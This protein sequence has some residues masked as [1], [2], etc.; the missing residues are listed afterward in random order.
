MIDC[1]PDAL[2]RHPN[3]EVYIMDNCIGCGNCA[4]NCPYGVIQ[5]AAVE[6]QPATNV[7][8]RLLFGWGG[9]GNGT[10][11]AEV[12]PKVA[13]KCDLCRELPA[14]RGEKRAACVSAC[15]TGAIARVNPKRYVDRLLAVGEDG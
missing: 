10:A 9:S 4:S 1:P 7:L 3:G 2:R 15:P 11:G 6:P 12:G 5:L 14:W 13:V 8:F